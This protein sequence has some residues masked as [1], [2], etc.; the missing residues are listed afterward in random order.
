M[1][2]EWDNQDT[3][4]ELLLEKYGELVKNAKIL[5]AF[6]SNYKKY[7]ELVR[8]AKILA[9][10]SN[11]NALALFLEMYKRFFFNCRSIVCYIIKIDHN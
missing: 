1:R 2:V 3:D 7:G 9:F 8:N 6:R 10:R 11:Y 5:L 4:F